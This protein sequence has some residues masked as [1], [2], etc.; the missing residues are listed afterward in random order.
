MNAILNSQLYASIRQ[1]S[2]SDGETRSMD[3]SIRTDH[4]SI[5]AHRVRTGRLIPTRYSL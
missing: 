5:N 4:T 1:H 2:D 3:L